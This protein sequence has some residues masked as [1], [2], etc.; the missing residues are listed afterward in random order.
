MQRV[1]VAVLGTG[2]G[3][4][5][6]LPGFQHVPEAELVAVFSQPLSEAQAA[7][8]AFHVP[9]A[10][11]DWKKLLSEAQPDLVT[12][13]LPPFLHRPAVLDALQAGCHVLCDKPMALDGSQAIE[14]LRAAEAAGVIH[15]LDHQL[16]FQPS[17][18][19]LKRLIDVGF[20]GRPLHVRY[21]NIN[22]N[23]GDPALPWHWIDDQQA[24]GGTLLSGASHHVDLMRWLFGEVRAVSGQ[25]GI[26]ITER[27]NPA[28][29]QPQPI[30]SDDQYSLVCDFESGVMAWLFA[31]S[32]ARHPGGLRLEVYGSE[33]SL[34]FT[35]A[36][37]LWGAP[38]GR[39]LEDLTVPDPNAA[40]PGVHAFV[41]TTAFVGLAQELVGAIADGR[42]LNAGATFYDGVRT[43]L[44]LDAGRRSWLERRWIEVN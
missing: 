4:M 38:A 20:V 35:E 37:G 19:R 32:V 25:L 11:D 43:Q 16:R 22:A 39:P 2:W 26:H 24:G 30:T 3:R 8:E 9:S 21:H 6:H 15:M 36:E 1:R 34:I 13:A 12:V 28:T 44:V 17:L 23:R 42:A 7:A 14:M 29:S 40:L 27:L 41:W 31:T 5:G 10:F 18:Q 33:G